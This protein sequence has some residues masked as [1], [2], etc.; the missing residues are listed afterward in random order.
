MKWPL[1]LALIRH[2]ESAF[3]ILRGQKAN[4][5]EYQ[6]FLQAFET[7]PL[8]PITKELAMRVWPRYRLAAGDWNTPPTEAGLS[9]A[10]KLGLGLPSVLD[11]PDIV[12]VSPHDR[13][14]ATLRSIWKSWPAL[15]NVKTVEEPRLHEQS[16]GFAVIYNDWRIFQ[17]LHP[18]QKMFYELEGP[19]WYRYPQGENVPDVIERMRSVI[20]TLVR[21]YSE[22]K[23]IVISHHL[24][25][26]S[27]MAALGRW[28]Q[29]EFLKWDNIKKPINCGV[30]IYRG[31]PT[32][33]DNGK[34]ELADYNLNLYE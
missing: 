16:H 9:Q 1:W 11:L 3:N 27:M 5:P 12:L 31:N 7:D 20:G 26:L 18:E 24:T 23:V 17:T 21:D 29:Q 6:Q 30:T 28:D 14:W 2:C 32:V 10:E 22:K 15:R 8:N 4:D 19:Y 33:G 25:I 13:T 34:L